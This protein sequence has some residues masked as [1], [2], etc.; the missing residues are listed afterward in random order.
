MHLFNL[1][2]L[3]ANLLQGGKQP[4]A[5]LLGSF[6]PFI[7]IIV[8]FWFLLFAPMR[9]QRKQ[10][11]KMI[12]ELKNGDKVVTTGGIYGVISGVQEDRFV[13]KISSDVK[14]EILKNA[15]AGKIEDKK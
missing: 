3:S 11:Q 7:L 4:Q 13:L 2:L 6:L 1:N 8:I 12:T 9:K 15:I 14:I 10:M 5:D